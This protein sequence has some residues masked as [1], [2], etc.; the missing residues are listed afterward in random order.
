MNKNR[1]AG[2]QGDQARSAPTP[3]AA[4]RLGSLDVFLLSV[5]CGLAAG[6]LEVATRVFCKRMG[7]AQ[8]LYLMSRHFLW[9]GPLSNLLLFSG[10]GM[11]LAA[12][13]R[14]RPRFGGLVG[15]RLVCALAPLPVAM[16]AGPFLYAE[17]WFLLLLGV[18]SR[19]VPALERH[20]A[21][22][23]RIVI[24]SLPGL[25]G[26]VFVLAGFVFGVDWIKQ[27]RESGRPSPSAAA[28]NV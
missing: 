12:L 15:P 14:A 27:H 23:R 16:V 7:V 6:W 18:A 25:V 3:T 22:L 24:V 28:P 19:L 8:P 21:T 1:F 10:L 20:P 5:W 4:P 2:R 26:L 9:L 13:T 17:A 11:G